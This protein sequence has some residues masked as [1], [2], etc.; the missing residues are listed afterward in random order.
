MNVTVL[1]ASK[2]KQDFDII[3]ELMRTQR[4]PEYDCTFDEYREVF[5]KM[6]QSPKLRAW[7][8]FA[9]GNAVG[10]IIARRQYVPKN[11]I[12]VIQL[13]LLEPARNKGVARCLNEKVIEW[14]VAN[15]AK[16][17]EWGSSYS[18][19]VWE[20]INRSLCGK[21]GTTITGQYLVRMEVP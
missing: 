5:L 12:D 10:Y 14:A 7:V 9:G 4:E 11:Q 13:Y 1:E 18:V 16:R 19:K 15:R 17:I 20:R 6:F 8:A 3:V 21:Y 2:I